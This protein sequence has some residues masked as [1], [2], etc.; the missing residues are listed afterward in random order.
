[1]SKTVPTRRPLALCLAISL[2]LAAPLSTAWAQR[3]G[4][5]RG[6]GNPGEGQSMRGGDGRGVGRAEG[7]R[8]GEGHMRSGARFGDR[9]GDR[10]PGGQRAVSPGAGAGPAPPVAQID[11]QRPGHA[12]NWRGAPVANV[13]GGSQ[14]GAPHLPR[15]GTTFRVPPHDAYALH[16]RGTPYRYGSGVWY[17]PSHNHWTVVRPPYGVVV[18]DL[19]WW[20]DVLIIGGL[21]YWLVN[22]IYYRQVA[23]GYEVVPPPPGAPQAVATLP[24]AGLPKQFVYPNLGQ[25]RATQ[26]DDEYDCHRWAAS[27]TGFDPSGTA[28]DGTLPSG[29]QRDDYL[30]ARAACLEGRGYT[31]R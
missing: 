10:D 24:A 25:S 15:P 19:P 1:M 13:N 6:D 9:A 2:A 17:R 30:R 23:N 5:R 16:W 8:P 28:L 7:H 31:V 12:G 4:E 21:S 3:G 29:T 22:D 14:H 20:R 26:D 27:Q 18:R 11:V